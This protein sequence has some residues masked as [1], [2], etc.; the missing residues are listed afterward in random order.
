M[1]IAWHRPNGSPVPMDCRYFD[2]MC[3]RD[4]T[5]TKF[6]FGYL[7]QATMKTTSICVL[8]FGYAILFLGPACRSQET[9]TGSLQAGFAAVD[10]TP[11]QFPVN[12]PGGFRDN[13]GTKV[14]DKF[15]SRAMVLSDGQTILTMVV[16]DNLG[17]GAT[18]LNEAKAIASKSTGIPV[19]RMLISCTH[20][21]SGPS[22]G[23]TSGRPAEVAYRLHFVKGVANSIITAHQNLQTATLGYESHPLPDEVFNRRWHLKPGKMPTN[24]F[25][26]M[27][28]VKMNPSNRPSVL[29]RPAGPTDP[30]ITVISVRD[31]RNKPLGLYANYSLHYVGGVPRGE[32][33]SDYFGIFAKLMPVRMRTSDKYVAMMSNGTSGDINNI[34]FGEIRPPRQSYEQMNIVA[35]K[36]ADTAWMA[37]QKID[38]YSGQIRLGFTQRTIVLRHRQVRE[39]TLARAKKIVAMTDETEINKLPRLAQIY[40]QRTLDL[41]KLSN[42]EKSVIVQAIRIGDMCVC[43]IPFET[44]VE[45]GLELKDRSPFAKTMVVSLA[46]ERYGYLPSPAQHRLGGYE[47][48]LGTNKVQKDASDIITKN[49]LEMLAELNEG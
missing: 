16:V 36:A 6:V 39:E 23:V 35:R 41:A 14:H 38:A 46:N 21:H 29:D 10:I 1:L 40:A 11:Q 15:H 3:K 27:D 45:I 13:L 30:D 43:A 25:G 26:E 8:T 22:S 47:T 24:P 12:L 49:L 32:L 31:K 44:L 4:A 20:T 37:D 42:I 18:E 7:L 9:E 19:E 33:S 5:L 34:P 2:T 17:G 48:W 28:E